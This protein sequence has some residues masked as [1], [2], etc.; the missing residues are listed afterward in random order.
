MRPLVLGGLVVVILAACGDGSHPTGA[1]SGVWAQPG[2][3]APAEQAGAISGQLGYPSEF[4]PGQAVYALSVDGRSY[5]KVESVSY[6]GRY[7]MQG[8]PTGDYFVYA[9][10]RW[11]NSQQRFGA[12]YTKAIACGLSVDCTDHSPVTV[13]VK[14]GQMTAGVDPSD[15]YAGPNDFPLIPDG[16]TS[17]ASPP[18]QTFESSEAAARSLGESRLLGRFVANQAD[19]RTNI[20][21]FWLVSTGNGH[22][23]SY[24]VAYAGSNQDLVRC[25]FYVVNDST[26]WRTLDVRC[27]EAAKGVSPTLHEL[28]RV[29]L[30]MGET[31]CVRVHTT[32]GI[33]ARVVKCLQPGTS[34]IIDDGP[35]YLPTTSSKP[36]AGPSQIDLWWHL[37]GY[38]WIVHLY[39]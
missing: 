17:S 11:G 27:T 22:N 31:G 38:G 4:L 30:G 10:A 14:A 8:V 7:T 33:T 12:G 24:Y 13:H 23:A 26:I 35:Y 29:R 19:C 21:C 20:A 15:W 6:Q 28:G 32:P 25:A 18:P 9:V 2:S 34:A 16:T 1:A 3:P 5:Y 36:P 37:A 39:L